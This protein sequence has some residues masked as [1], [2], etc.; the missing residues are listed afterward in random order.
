MAAKKSGGMHSGKDRKHRGRTSIT[1][2]Q[3]PSPTHP[4]VP[5]VQRAEV[6]RAVT[7]NGNMNKHRGDRRDMS[8]AYTGN[9]RHAARGNTPRRDVSTRAR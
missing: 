2:L 6:N 4:M 5:E 9:E 1:K 8:K 7:A 3:Q